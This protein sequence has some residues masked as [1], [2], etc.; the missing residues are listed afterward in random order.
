MPRHRKSAR[1]NVFLNSRLVG[2]LNHEA[3][4]A[5]DFRYDPDWLAWEHTLPISLSLP[6]REDRY[7]GAPVSAVFDNLL[8]DNDGIRKKIAVRVGAEGVD[9]FSLLSALGRDCV[10]ALQFLPEGVDPGPAGIIKGHPI[11]DSDIAELIG[12]LA[13]SPL[14]L[15]RDDDFRISITGAQEKTALLRHKG[16]WQKP[17]GTTATTHILKP[18]IGQLPNGIDLTNSVENEYLCLTLTKA[19]GLP[20]AHVEMTTFGEKRVLIVERF[21]R[22]F[23]KDGRLLRVPQEDCCQALSVPWPRKYEGDGGP[24]VQ[25]ILRLLAGSDDAD[26]DRR[27]F[28]KAIIVFWLLA[29]TDGHAKNF[30]VQLSSGGGYRLAPLYDVVSAQPSL[31]ASQIRRNK[32]KM[33]MAVG[34]SRHYAVERISGRHFIQSAAKAGLGK[35]VALGVIGEVVDTAA[36]ALERVMAKLPKGF[37]EKIAASV[38]RGVRARVEHL[39]RESG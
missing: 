18:Q 14:G 8:P 1:L 37:P 23:T 9:P 11:K 25:Q 24:G 10:G 35:S 5:I 12:N 28:L 34:D 36:G 38:E 33:A 2:Q 21:D 3:S 31:D 17:F 13:R 22:L 16:R 19:F 20:S 4:G 30:S 6:L 29:A 7:I 15:E 27:H 26:T 39:A 32:M